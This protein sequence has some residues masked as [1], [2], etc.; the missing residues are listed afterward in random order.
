MGDKLDRIP[1][2]D[3][4]AALHKEIR[5]AAEQAQTLPSDSQRIIASFRAA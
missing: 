1:L 3:A 5:S 4:I 2:T